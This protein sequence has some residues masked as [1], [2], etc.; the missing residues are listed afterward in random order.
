MF[1]RHLRIRI[2]HL[3]TSNKKYQGNSKQPWVE[4]LKLYLT[5]TI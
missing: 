2:N 1:R 3:N 4:V 5:R